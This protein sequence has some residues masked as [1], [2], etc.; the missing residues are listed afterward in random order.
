MVCLRQIKYIIVRRF[1]VNNVQKGKSGKK[2]MN[3]TVNKEM[4]LEDNIPTGLQG[5]ILKQATE[6]SH[7]ERVFRVAK[8]GE[9]EERVFLN[10]Y[11]EIQAGYIGDNEE[12][13][14]KD[15][16]GTYST[17]VYTERKNCDKF[18]NLLKNS[19]RLRKTYPYPIVIQGRTSRGLVQRTI[20]R[21]PSYSDSTHI[22]WWLF[23]GQKSI[24][25]G[26]FVK[27]D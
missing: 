27:C 13:Y 21:V 1:Y 16:I 26:D 11:G 5:D 4:E 24:V 23:R 25:L 2:H 7:F 14:P 19:V 9:I 3:E 20:E 17:S 6:C 10:T 8:W 12:K 18:I 22:D 15:D